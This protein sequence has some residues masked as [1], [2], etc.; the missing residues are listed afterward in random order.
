MPN[1]N[2]AKNLVGGTITLIKPAD[3]QYWFVQPQ[4][5]N[6]ITVTIPGK[7]GGVVLNPNSLGAGYA[8]D[9]LDQD[10]FPF[11]FASMTLTAVGNGSATDLFCAWSDPHPPY[12][13]NVTIPF[14][15]VI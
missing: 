4:G 5:A 1:F 9:W 7:T 3:H 2:E 12:S 10:R 14:Q 6:P 8:G 13:Y 11:K 15:T